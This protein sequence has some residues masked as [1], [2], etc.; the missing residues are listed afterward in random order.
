M[1]SNKPIVY[2]V[3]LNWNGEKDTIDMLF[4]LTKIDYTNFHIVLVDNGS[5]DSSFN[6]VRQWLEVSEYYRL[7]VNKTPFENGIEV[8]GQ[9]ERVTLL[10]ST[11]NLGFSKGSNVGCRY[12][13]SL[14]AEYALLLNNDTEVEPNFLSLL[15]AKYMETPEIGGIIPQIRYFH[16]K[17]L[18]W[19]CGGKLFLGFRKYY[20]A[21]KHYSILPNKGELT[22]SYA[23]GC[24]LLFKPKETGIL[25]EK[26]FFGEEDF[27][28]AYRMKRMNKKMVCVLDSIIYHKVGQSIHRKVKG[29]NKGAIFIH[30]LNRFVNMKQ[31]FNNRFVWELWRIFYCLYIFLLLINRIRFNEL[32]AFI[33]KLLVRSTKIDCVN[34]IEFENTLKTMNAN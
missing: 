15:M 30:Y 23:T 1:Q 16:N 25:T 5:D 14:N 8:V 27:E 4:S 32:I 22:V 3:T 13:L 21:G 6:E 7:K 12:A 10:K 31:Q 17:E 2:I 24:A 18:I 33:A 9:G 19:N 20:F 11:E 29:V 28:F 34:K 26:F